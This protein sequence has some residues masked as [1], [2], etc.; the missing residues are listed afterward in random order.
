[1]IVRI[2]FNS[3][4]AIYQQI[5]HQII[6]GIASNQLHDGD[7]LP[8]VRSMADDIGINMHTVNKAY[9]ILRQE[10]YVQVDRRRG[11]IVSLNADKYVAMQ[12]LAEELKVSLAK[13]NCK[14]I[15]KAE[16]LELVDMI[17]D[18]YLEENGE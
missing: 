2:N 5:C 16:V 6:I 15:T 14:N 8:S 4:E 10:G 1:M 11:V 12:E 7:A 18:Q 9:T 13:A 3:D 17:Y